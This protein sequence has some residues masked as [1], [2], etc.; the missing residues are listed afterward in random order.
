MLKLGIRDL[1]K[2][3][4]YFADL[5]YTISE[6]PHAVLHDGSEVGY[7][8]LTKGSQI[9]GQ[10]IAH[11]IDRHYYAL[12]KTEGAADREVIE[13]LMRAEHGEMWRVPVE[14]VVVIAMDEVIESAVKYADSIP[15]AEAEEAL[16]HYEQKPTKVIER[17]TRRLREQ[18]EDDK[19]K[20]PQT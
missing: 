5:G 18:Q 19:K 17:F 14:D 16:R 10:V 11:Y 1:N 4:K 12:M 6:G 13:E 2:L 20:N 8:V 3:L 9:V 15:S 7:W